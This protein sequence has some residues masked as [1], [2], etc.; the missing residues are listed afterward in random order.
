[1]TR[2]LEHI[3]YAKAEAQRLGAVME[4]ERAK[5]HIVGIIHMN[6]L[7]RKIFFS[8]SPRD[9][10]VNHVVAEDVRRKV[11]EMSK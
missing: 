3:E 7:S 8:T 9:K 4:I 11:K 2:Q 6:G 1:M 10:K 5:K